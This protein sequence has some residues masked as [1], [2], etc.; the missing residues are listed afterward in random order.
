MCQKT[1]RIFF[2]P[3]LGCEKKKAPLTWR[4]IPFSQWLIT[5]V[6]KSPMD[7]VVGPLPNGH[8]KWLKSTG[9]IDHRVSV[10][11]GMI[12]QVRVS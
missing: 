4:I 8:K 6:N 12:L 11:P 10:R 2:F 1:G 3:Q 9:V 5:R 7:R